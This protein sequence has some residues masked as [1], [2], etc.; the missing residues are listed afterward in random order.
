MEGGY[1]NDDVIQEGESYQWLRLILGGGGVQ[2]DQESYD[3]I[4]ERSLVHVRFI[5]LLCADIQL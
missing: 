3:V 4:C 1:S 5:K 2:N